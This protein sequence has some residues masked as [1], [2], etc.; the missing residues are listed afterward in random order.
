VSFLA[1]LELVKQHEV[2]VHQADHF[3]EIHLHPFEVDAVAI[4]IQEN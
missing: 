3:A 4:Q 2:T 1:L